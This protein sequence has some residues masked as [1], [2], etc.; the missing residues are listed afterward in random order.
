MLFFELFSTRK[1]KTEQPNLTSIVIGQK[2]TNQIA[3]YM[4]ESWCGFAHC[5][6]RQEHLEGLSII[7]GE[8]SDSYNVKNSRCLQIFILWGLA[9]LHFALFIAILWPAFGLYVW[10]TCTGCTSLVWIWSHIIT[11]VVSLCWWFNCFDFYRFLN[12]LAVRKSC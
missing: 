2:S 7:F 12:G 1:R 4:V 11:E 9:G 6:R 3:Q 5:Y 10:H 8:Y